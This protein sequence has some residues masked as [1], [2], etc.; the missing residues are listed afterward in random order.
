MRITTREFIKSLGPL[1]VWT[2]SVWTQFHRNI[3]IVSAVKCENNEIPLIPSDPFA[4]ARKSGFIEAEAA[5]QFRNSRA[6]AQ[7]TMGFSVRLSA[8]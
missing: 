3:N 8:F 4:N 7:Q 2:Q 1:A 5:R 6:A